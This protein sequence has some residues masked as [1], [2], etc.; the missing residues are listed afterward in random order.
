MVSFGNSPGSSRARRPPVRSQ[1]SMRRALALLAVAVSRPLKGATSTRLGCLS[2]AELTLA[3]APPA[4]APDRSPRLRVADLKLAAGPGLLPGLL[5]P[6]SGTSG[7]SPYARLASLA[8]AG[9][10][11]IEFDRF[12]ASAA[13][14]I[15]L[16]Y[17]QAR[18]RIRD[19]AAASLSGR[20]PSCR[21]PAPAKCQAG[22]ETDGKL[23]GASGQ[24][25]RQPPAT[26]TITS[27]L[28]AAR[29]DAEH[30]A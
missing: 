14:T 19:G 2:C 22:Q 28:Q 9:E 16:R 27:A 18:S 8:S 4:L 25:N 20:V 12:T 11:A 1:P 3:D 23:A 5:E 10:S 21:H 7:P 26:M 29:L 30:R 24:H 13:M 17:G 15:V 6:L